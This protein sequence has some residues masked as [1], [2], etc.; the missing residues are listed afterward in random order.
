MWEKPIKWER[1]IKSGTHLKSSPSLL[2]SCCWNLRR[3]ESEILSEGEDDW[4]R[5][6]KHSEKCYIKTRSDNF[7][8]VIWDHN[9]R[10][11]WRIGAKALW[12]LNS[13]PMLTFF[14]ISL[15]LVVKSSSIRFTLNLTIYISLDLCSRIVLFCALSICRNRSLVFVRN[16]A[17]MCNVL[18]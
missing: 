13:W 16:W 18:C 1:I 17:G 6:K 3:W 8:S 2:F 14:S 10:F 5:N 7:Y 9:N 11:Q 12:E 4:K 15:F